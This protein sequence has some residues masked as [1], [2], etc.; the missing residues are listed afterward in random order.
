MNDAAP[1][2][3]PFLQLENIGKNFGGTV[4]LESIDWSVDPGEIHCLVGENG[5]GK[6][7]LIKIIAGVHPPNVGGRIVVGGRSFDHLLPH[8]S[9]QLGIQ[10]IYQDL[11]LFPNLSVWENI[12]IDQELGPPY[13]TIDRK[14]MRC[15]ALDTLKGLDIQLPLDAMVKQ[16]SVAERQIIAICRGL[17]SDAKLLF[18]D[19]PTASLT[20][21]EVVRLVEIIRKLKD[22]GVAVVFVSHRLEEVMTLAE[23][24][25][26]LRDGR[27]VGTF[28]S[29]EVDHHRLVEL[30]TGSR[31]S[32]TISARK[33]NDQNP[34]L[35]VVGASRH[36]E[37]QDVSFALH[38][39][40][41]LGI[42]GLIGSGRTEM[43]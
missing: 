1:S 18:M 9:K 21:H 6:S 8:I 43:E 19:E 5:S 39:G 15:K 41:I 40:E 16:L 4:A 34:V 13:A 26:I 22:F 35:E 7:T 14:T 28:P 38:A 33:V 11:S 27:K 31:I 17:A 24:V 42:I 25:T 3:V 10:V 12:A 2:V 37:F 30:M 32:Q 29:D 20:Q 23:R 36:G